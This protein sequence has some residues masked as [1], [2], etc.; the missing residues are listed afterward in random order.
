MAYCSKSLS[1][2]STNY[3][4]PGDILRHRE[5]GIQ[6]RRTALLPS[7]FLFDQFGQISK[8]VARG[9]QQLVNVFNVV[10]GKL[11]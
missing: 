2:Q 8:I 1:D 11:L 9:C 5:R 10:G 3:N 6:K 7:L 4:I